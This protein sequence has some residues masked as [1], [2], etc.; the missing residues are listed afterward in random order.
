MK[1]RLLQKKDIRSA[2]KIVGLNY[3]LEYERKSTLEL[4]DMFGHSA[5]KPVY[6]VAEDKKKIVDFAGFIQSW[7]DYN[8][9]QIFWVNVLPE[10]QRQGIGKELVARIIKEIRKKKD[11]QLILLTADGNTKNEKYYQKYFGFKTIGLFD[12]KSY[13]LMSLLLE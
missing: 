4:K 10:K 3:S 12:Q 8:I 13:H 2:A 6:Y 7:M 11:A 1:I 5:I 9:Y